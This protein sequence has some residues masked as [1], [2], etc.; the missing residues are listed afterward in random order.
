[1]SQKSY[2]KSV[3]G[4]TNMPK[5]TKRVSPP[6]TFILLHGIGQTLSSVLSPNEA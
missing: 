6:V 2:L 5:N 1:M 3:P 4:I